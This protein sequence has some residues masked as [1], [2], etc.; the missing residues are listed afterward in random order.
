VRVCSVDP[1][2]VET[3]FSLV[4][5]HGDQARADGVYRS[6]PPL[7]ADDVAAC[8]VFCA[9]RPPHVAVMD[10]VVMPQDQASVYASHARGV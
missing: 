8:V 2:M 5:F 9:T 1:G 10:L 6:Y 7:S 4:R 3:E